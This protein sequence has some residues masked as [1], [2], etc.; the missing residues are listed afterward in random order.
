[1]I[2]Q[3]VESPMEA[4][5]WFFAAALLVIVGTY[6]LF[7]AGSIA[8][9]KWMKKGSVFITGHPVLF[10]FPACFTG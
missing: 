9:L 5:L 8:L 4:M 6:G 10:L 2:A 1:M 3:K 7:M